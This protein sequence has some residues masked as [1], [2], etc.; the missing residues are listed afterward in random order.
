M[1]YYFI[2]ATTH[3]NE[4]ST[5]LARSA[6]ALQRSTGASST[7]AS[8]PTPAAT[9]GIE[10]TVFSLRP[11]ELELKNLLAPVAAGPVLERESAERASEDATVAPSFHPNALKYGELLGPGQTPFPSL[12]AS[13][14]PQQAIAIEIID[15]LGTWSWADAT[16]QAQAA[17]TRLPTHDEVRRHLAEHKGQPLFAAGA[18]IT[19]I[20]SSPGRLT[21]HCRSDAPGP[22]D[23]TRPDF[24]A[25][26]RMNSHAPE[27]ELQSER[28]EPTRGRGSESCVAMAAA[29]GSPLREQPTT[30][31]MQ[32]TEVTATHVT[33]EELA[34]RA[35]EAKHVVE[36]QAAGGL[37]FVGHPRAA[38][39]SRL[40]VRSAAVPDAN[41]HPHYEAGTFHEGSADVMDQKAAGV[42]LERSSDAK[43]EVEEPSPSRWPVKCI[44]RLLLISYF[45]KIA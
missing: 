25:R 13:P 29:S 27:R 26:S 37:Q 3:V 45:L 15:T 41:D 23:F 21:A 20:S 12:S 40:F 39:N 42:H 10:D 30:R 1:N 8:P 9:G 28:K 16:A 22:A 17:D 31:P 33:A 35:T 11:T 2:V 44:E 6:A 34:C 38:V 19:P 14:P 43:R 7:P 24:P 32:A 4:L 5:R 36:K 18:E